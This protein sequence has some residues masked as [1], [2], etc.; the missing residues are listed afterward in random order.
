M[1]DLEFFLLF[2]KELPCY[3]TKVILGTIKIRWSAEYIKS[4]KI[5]SILVANTFISSFTLKTSNQKSSLS[6]EVDTNKAAIHNCLCNCYRP[7]SARLRLFLSIPVNK[8]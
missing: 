6:T 1:N 7:Q 8:H 5:N 3:E 4:E 2:D